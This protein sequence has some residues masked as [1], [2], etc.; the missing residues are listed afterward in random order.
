MTCH[1]GQMASRWLPARFIPV[2][3]ADALSW[4]AKV[5][6]GAVCAEHARHRTHEILQ[7]GVVVHR[8]I[9]LFDDVQKIAWHVL[10][11]VPRYR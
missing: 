1:S 3:T 5:P 10:T 6:G 8:G 11:V 4:I 7:V 9:R 2:E